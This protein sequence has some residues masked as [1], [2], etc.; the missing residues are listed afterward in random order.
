VRTYLLDTNTCIRALTGNPRV[1]AKLLSKS[2][3][4]LRISVITE[5]ELR[6]GAEKSGAR[7]RALTRLENFLRPLRVEPFTSEDAAVYA[8]VRARLEKQGT[9]IGPLDTLIAAHALSRDHWVV[10]ANTDE[11][12]RVEK[13]RLE[14]WE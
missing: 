4:A 6:L 3:D 1:L 11:F 9:P 12:S 7:T 10:T 5:G 13:L 14:N 2:P 8:R